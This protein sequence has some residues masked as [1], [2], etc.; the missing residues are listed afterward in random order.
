MGIL[1]HPL[2]RNP[3]NNVA[4]TAHE[5]AASQQLATR[6]LRRNPS[7]NVA[8]KKNKKISTRTKLPHVGRTTSP[9]HKPSAELSTKKPISQRRRVA[10][11]VNS[12]SSYAPLRLCENCL[13]LGRGLA[14]GRSD[15]HVV[16]FV[17]FVF[18]KQSPPL[19][20]PIIGRGILDNRA[21]DPCH[22]CHPWFNKCPLAKISEH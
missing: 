10:E 17:F 3:T 7:N 18:K 22:P 13:L 4:P 14:A 16:P 21:T 11:S 9:S 6:E 1:S 12:N 8:P 20:C 5:L 2:R 19:S 15:F